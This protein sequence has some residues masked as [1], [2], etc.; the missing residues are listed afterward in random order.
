MDQT[1]NVLMSMLQNIASQT[2]ALPKTRG[3]GDELS[4]FQKLL[5]KKAQEKD[6]LL[7]EPSKAPAKAETP[8]KKAEKAPAQ[9]ED[10]PVESSKKLQAFLTPLDPSVL[11]QYPP[12]WL[13]ANLEEGEAVFCIGVRTGNNGE[14]IPILVGAEEAARIF[15]R[16]V[17]DVSD[18]EAD[19]I[20]EATA[21]GADNSPAA[22]LEKVVNDEIGHVAEEAVAESAPK[23]D[24]DDIQAELIDVDRAPQ[25]LF[26]NVEAAPVKVGETESP[27]QV[28]EADVVS[29]VDAQI[30]QAMQAGNSTVTVKLTPEHLGEVTVQV[31]MKDNG[32]L[33]IAISARSDDTRALLERHAVH[34][35]ELVGSRVREAV[36]V[37]V[38]RGQ[39]NQQSQNQQ[40]SYDGHNGHAQ[41]ERQERRQQRGHTSSQDFMQ[42]LRLG[43]IPADG[44]L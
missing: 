27:R 10:D 43:L 36:E 2:G 40:H 26:H 5:D 37:S 33:A 21:P 13:P 41:E 28:D 12:E 42:Q 15:D 35:Q 30:A 3:D 31:S 22:L 39:E 11:A 20:L 1:N 24:D 32:L 8:N 16:E 34:L 19:A 25:R 44:E 4:E 9:K 23:N 7:E 14:D 38:Q 17:I 29:Q 6:P 18:P